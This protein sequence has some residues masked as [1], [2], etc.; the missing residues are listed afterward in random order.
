MS[1]GKVKITKCLILEC[2]D[3]RHD[4]GLG[5]SSQFCLFHHLERLG[6]SH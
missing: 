1:D 5:M 2:H 3:I 4:L 6:I